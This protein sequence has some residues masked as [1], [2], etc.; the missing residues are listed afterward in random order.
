VTIAGT[1]CDVSTVS[2][3]QVVCTTNQHNKSETVKIEVQVAGNGIATQVSK[4]GF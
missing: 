3:T 2:N 1:P 4:D